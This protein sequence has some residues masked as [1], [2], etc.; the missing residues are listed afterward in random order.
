MNNKKNVKAPPQSK[1]TLREN[2][3]SGEDNKSVTFSIVADGTAYLA[4]V[5]PFSFNDETRF[6]IRINGG[7]QHVFTWDQEIPGYRAI[8][9]EASLLPD[10]LEQ[11]LSEKLQS[12]L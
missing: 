8:D 5:S 2:P 10:S 9:D 6:Y 3:A 1:E 4:K 7:V 11:A 12:L